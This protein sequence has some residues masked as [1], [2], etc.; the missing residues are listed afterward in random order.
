MIAATKH[1]H[2]L[3]SLSA[4]ASLL[5]LASCAPTQNSKHQH[6]AL[7]P[8]LLVKNPELIGS[9]IP[10]D[11]NNPLILPGKKDPGYSN[12]Y[13]T[14]TH[15]HFA[16][17]PSYP[18]TMKHWVDKKRMETLSSG[19]SKLIIC[20]PQQRARVYVDGICAM[21]WPVSTGTKGHLT[22]TGVFRV[23]EKKEK[24]ASN[25]YG[26]VI[27]SKGKT[28]QSDTDRAKGIPAGKTFRGASMPFWHRF[29]ND[30]VGLHSGRVVAGRQLSH[31]C[32]R[33][34]YAAAK[35]FFSY[36]QMTMPVYITRG[37]EDYIGGGRVS[38]AD[39]RYRPIPNNDYSDIVPSD[40]KSPT[41]SSPAL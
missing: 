22:P 6:E 35:Q 34:P 21:D 18:K 38:P 10:T 1:L 33:T 27:S 23:I 39:V 12:P 14:G 13:P 8:T 30:G 16:A 3:G 11:G 19:N 40:T 37:V 41:F 24:H 17:N 15:A 26:R 28:E 31:G 7:S 32:I 36:S 29:S 4:L 5:I 9:Y 2:I 25:R 20:L